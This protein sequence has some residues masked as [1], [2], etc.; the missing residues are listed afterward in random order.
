[1][2]D[3]T[4]T[5]SVPKTLSQVIYNYIR[6]GIISGKFKARQKINDKEIADLFHVS[7]TP[8]REAVLRLGAE[9]FLTLTSHREAIVKPISFKELREILHLLILLDGY[10]IQTALSDISEEAIDDLQRLFERLQTAQRERRTEEFDGLIA[11]LRRRLWECVPNDFLKDILC[12]IQNQYLRYSAA[13]RYALQKDGVLDIILSVWEP[14][15]GFVRARDLRAVH[16]LL[17]DRG[18]ENF[19][20]LPLAEGLRE[21]LENAG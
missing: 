4:A 14:L 13:R 11:A 10:A 9:G 19:L 5:F 18:I 20:P 8:V 21:Y 15:L 2:N 12:G 1:M 17:A 16:E 7:T 6:D 3:E